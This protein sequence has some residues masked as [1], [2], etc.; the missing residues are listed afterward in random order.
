MPD[1][2]GVLESGP[3]TERELSHLDSERA[4]PVSLAHGAA[5]DKPVAGLPDVDRRQLPGPVSVAHRTVFNRT[6]AD[7]L[8]DRHQRS[9]RALP[10][11]VAKGVAFELADRVLHARRRGQRRAVPVAVRVVLTGTDAK[12][13]HHRQ[14]RPGL[15]VP[16]ADDRTVAGAVAIAFVPHQ[17]ERSDATLSDA[18]A[19]VA[20]EGGSQAV[21]W[22]GWIRTIAWRIQSPLPYRLATPHRCAHRLRATGGVP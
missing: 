6:D 12:R 9:G 17:Y 13:L 20:A 10:D 2:D 7:R 21:R 16:D 15:A 18:E 3:I 22:G 8:S 11:T 14:Q 1:A 4:Q 19:D 5:L